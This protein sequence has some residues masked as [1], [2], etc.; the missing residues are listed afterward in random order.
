MPFTLAI[1]L[2]LSTPQLSNYQFGRP[3]TE[4]SDLYSLGSTLICL[5]T[6]TRST[7]IHKL[8]DDHYRFKLRELLP[9]LNGRFVTWLS[10]LVEPSSKYRYANAAVALAALTPIEVREGR[11]KRIGVNLLKVA[12]GFSVIT[13]EVAWVNSRVSNPFT[14]PANHYTEIPIRPESQADSVKRLIDT[15]MCRGCDLRQAQLANFNLQGVD[16]TYAT[17]EGANLASANLQGSTLFGANLKN[18]NL[19]HA[20]LKGAKLVQVNLT[21]SDLTSANLMGADLSYSK[22]QRV[23]L[24]GANLSGTIMPDRSIHP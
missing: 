22:L 11:A 8:L 20:N 16:L 7:E 24:K 13:S 14:S 10:K 3:L 6:G 21:S 9:Q 1:S 18:V 2:V 12:I 4:A 17:L 15:R 23:K 19:A 5:L